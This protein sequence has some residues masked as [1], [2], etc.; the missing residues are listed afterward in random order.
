M[1]RV[2][3]DAEALLQAPPPAAQLADAR[4]RLAHEARGAMLE[5][6][7]L[8]LLAFAAA[9]GLGE[10]MLRN[11]RGRLGAEPPEVA[12]LVRRV[13]AGD[14]AVDVPLRAGDRRSVVYAM[15]LMVERLS[16]TLGE[17]RAS[18]DALVAAAREIAASA[19]G[20]AA[21]ASV[22]AAGVE[23]VGASI[24]QMD[25][26][27]S[28]NREN[29]GRTDAIA[30]D[31][32]RR[33]GEG[34]DAVR[35]TVAAM[36]DIT[37]RIAII[38]EIAYQTN[39]LALNAA[40][41]AARA[42]TSGRG[43]AVV[44]AEVRKLAERSQTA[45]H[46]ISGRAGGSL[47]VAESAGGILAA[48][49]PSIERTS[50][51]VQEIA[52]A[53]VEQAAGVREIAASM[54]ELR[55][56]GEQNAAVSEQLAAAAEE[57]RGQAGSLQEQMAYFRVHGAE[58]AD[59]SAALAGAARGL[60]F[61]KV[62]QAHLDWTGKLQEFLHGR[63]QTLDPQTLERDDAC[64]LGGWIHGD[65]ARL[66][67]D[68]DYRRLRAIHADFHRCC[69]EVARRHLRHERRA[70]R[71]L[72]DG[73]FADLTFQTVNQLDKLRAKYQGACAPRPRRA[74]RVQ[75]L[76]SGKSSS[77]NSNSRR[78]APT[79]VSSSSLRNCTRRILPEMVFGS[80]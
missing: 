75:A 21:A 25:A 44:A 42:G 40:I 51:L 16:A 28:H 52:A 12:A 53:S 8:G 3:R 11:L 35:E 22:Q 50:T 62:R 6:G 38:D 55:R 71:E 14:L 49:V 72:L 13:A 17:V 61:G 37:E 46:A 36:Q 76:S 23:R 15:R 33:A 64:M 43:F 5:A 47:R 30:A 26:A 29:A 79:A 10:L 67:E 39:M 19:Q 58:A 9:L 18:A 57:M 77:W 20:M 48:M 34:G 63:G 68:A 45:A 7:A 73:D 56:A 59:R 60:D 66:G 4:A 80:S 70:A 65:G 32:V 1:L 54:G 2:E 31:A 41:E 27:I 69:G 78:A 24:E 74:R